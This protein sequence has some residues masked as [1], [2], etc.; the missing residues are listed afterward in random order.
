M[1][2][3]LLVSIAAVAFVALMISNAFATTCP[4]GF[5][6]GFWKH[7]IGVYLYRH[8]NGEVGSPGDYNAFGYRVPSGYRDGWKLTDALMEE[9]LGYIHVGMPSL[10]MQEAYDALSAHGFPGADQVRNDMA[11]I[12]NSAAGYGPF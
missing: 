4:P 10:T 11:N 6:P 7:D 12:W 1:N 8:T 3:K 5:T 2:K 9:F